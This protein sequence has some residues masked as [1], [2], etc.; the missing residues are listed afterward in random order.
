[1][2][3]RSI[4]AI[5]ASRALCSA[6]RHYFVAFDEATGDDTDDEAMLH[7]LA[8]AENALEAAAIAYSKEVSRG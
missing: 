6:A 8:L 1:V 7:K 4:A 3:K 2:A 5:K